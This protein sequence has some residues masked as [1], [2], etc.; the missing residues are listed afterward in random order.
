MNNIKVFKRHELKYILT[1]EQFNIIANIIDLY[2]DKEEYFNSTIRN[3]Y[4]DTP[5]Y[6]LIRNSIEKPEYKEK[7]RIRAYK[8]VKC[9]EDVFVEIKKKY[10]KVVYKRREVLPYDKAKLFFDEK[11]MPND[12]QITKEIDYA[13][14]YYKDLKPS[15]F[16]SYNRLAYRGK[17]DKNLRITFDRN[18]VWRDYDIDLTKDVYG[19]YLLPQELVLMEVKT[20]MG[21]PKWLLDFLGTNKIYKRSFSKYGNVYMKLLKKADGMEEIK[22]A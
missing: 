20:L 21:L 16:L 18:I 13:I 15:I 10:N 5:N 11:I 9:N 7:I 22:Y 6:Y 14:N 3:I 12:L 19:E 1:K 4:Y 8:T 2:M 17:E